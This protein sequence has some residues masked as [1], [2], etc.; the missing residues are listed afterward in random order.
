MSI[1][2]GHRFSQYR[3]FPPE[4]DNDP[5]WSRLDRKTIILFVLAFGVPA[6]LYVAV[7]IMMFQI[8]WQQPAKEAPVAV[9]AA[10]H[11]PTSDVARA[12][13]VDKSWRNLEPALRLSKVTIEDN[14]NLKINSRPAQLYGFQVI[15]RS[16]ICTHKNGERWACGQRAYV[17]LL[18]AMGST[19]VDCRQ[20]DKGAPIDIDA[21]RTFVCYLPGTDLAELMLRQGWGTVPEGVNDPRYL[22]AAEMARARQS[23]MWRPLPSSP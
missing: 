3:P 13:L 12:D 1:A 21:P 14:N 15:P 5:W 8:S 22:A 23:G 4:P 11:Q 20:N 16:K 10:S 6:T 17:A 19:T 18:N 7:K 9:M 2:G